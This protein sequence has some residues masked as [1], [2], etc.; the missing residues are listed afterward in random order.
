[1]AAAFDRDALL[2]AFD[3]IGRAA[4]KA[5]TKLQIAVYGGSALMLASN[6]RFATEDVDVSQLEHPLPD[7]LAAVV[8]E[9]AEKNCWQDNW[10]NDGVAFHLSSLADHAIDHLEFGTFPRDGTSPGLAVSVP[11]A[12]YLL[13]LKLKAARILDPLRGETERLDILNLMQVV[14]IA[15]VEEAIAL[16]GRYF[17]V[18]AA[19]SEK[20]RFL[21]SNMNRDGGID[22][23]KYPR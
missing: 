14:G 9:I 13:A 7:W 22:A 16:L 4:V 2:D 23:P 21:L 5:G 10:F 18:S 19:S 11:S 17:P 12:E 8:H 6:F 20:Q 3:Q 15:T 1:M